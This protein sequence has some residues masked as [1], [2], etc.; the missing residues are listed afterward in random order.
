[1]TQTFIP[2]IQDPVVS[3]LE[4]C[5]EID[6]F[7]KYR[8]AAGVG[9]LGSALLTASLAQAAAVPPDVKKAL[10]ST[11]KTVDTL[12]SV[13][14]QG[15]LMALTPFAIFISFKYLRTVMR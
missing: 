1:M 10:D 7:E 14:Y 2:T 4:S 6:Y 3:Y 15:F 11:Q 13:V 5:C 12:G 9:L 8:T